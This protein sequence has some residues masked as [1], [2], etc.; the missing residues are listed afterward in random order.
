MAEHQRGGR[1]GADDRVAVADGV[2]E[3][4]EVR[5]GQ[6]AGVVDVAGDQRGHSRAALAGGT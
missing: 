2:A 1:L 3:D 6:V 4:A 5:Q